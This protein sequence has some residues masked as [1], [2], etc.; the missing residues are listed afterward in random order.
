MEFPSELLAD[1]LPPRWHAF[2]EKERNI[3]QLQVEFNGRQSVIIRREV[4]A[5]VSG[6][7]EPTRHSR[8]GGVTEASAPVV[9]ICR[10]PRK[11]SSERMERRGMV[12]GQCGCNPTIRFFLD[13]EKIP[14]RQGAW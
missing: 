6:F 12:G 3:S 14:A 11:L 1:A 10:Y 2:L 7:D 5:V 9:G 8:A 13:D 4:E